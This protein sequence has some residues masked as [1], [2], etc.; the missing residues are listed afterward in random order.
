MIFR[1]I[2][3]ITVDKYLEMLSPLELINVT[4]SAH[5]APPAD[6]KCPPAPQRKQAKRACAQIN[7]YRVLIVRI[8]VFSINLEKFEGS[9]DH[10]RAEYFP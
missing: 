2:S 6:T 5:R 8:F 9:H 10:I 4:P 3:N 7:I 1:A